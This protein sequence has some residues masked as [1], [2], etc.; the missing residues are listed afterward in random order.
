MSSAR[1]MLRPPASNDSVKREEASTALTSARPGG[2][3]T[4]CAKAP[5]VAEAETDRRCAGGAGSNDL[6]AAKRLKA[7]PSSA[8]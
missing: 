4:A 7:Q 1:H 8:G 5:S 3:G 6:S 2:G